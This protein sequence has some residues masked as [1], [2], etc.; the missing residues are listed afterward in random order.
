M[1]Y[2][3]YLLGLFITCPSPQRLPSDPQKFH[4]DNQSHLA[5]SFMG[6][7]GNSLLKSTTCKVPVI[8]LTLSSSWGGKALVHDPRGPSQSPKVTKNATKITRS[9]S[10]GLYMGKEGNS[11]LKSITYSQPVIH[12]TPTPSWSGISPT[13]PPRGHH[14][15]LKAT[16]NS[17]EITRSHLAG[18]FMGQQGN[19]LLKSLTCKVLLM[20]LTLSTSW[21]GASPMHHL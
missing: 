20:R 8:C 7:E 4:W 21:V 17:T 2:P 14:Q 11:Y 10:A 13:H 6:N 16:K 15:S 1:F 18:L 9:H 19:W 12:S 3:V 5:R